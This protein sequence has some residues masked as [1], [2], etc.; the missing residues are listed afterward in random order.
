M[1]SICSLLVDCS[2]SKRPPIFPCRPRPTIRKRSPGRRRKG[3]IRAPADLIAWRASLGL[4]ARL[5]VV[6]AHSMCVIVASTLFESTTSA[7]TAA[8]P[9]SI[10]RYDQF[11]HEASNRFALPEHWIRAIIKI[12][13]AGDAHAVSHRGAMGL[14]QLM[15]GTWIEL[16]VRHGLGL[17]PFDPRENILAGTAYLKEMHD[18]LRPTTPVRRGMN[19][20]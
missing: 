5:I 9:Q 10:D 19:S 4:S 1:H 13:S 7:Q 14:M 8:R 11:I 15:P 17:D 2:C 3:H 20:T 12:E 18:R 6:I 16:S